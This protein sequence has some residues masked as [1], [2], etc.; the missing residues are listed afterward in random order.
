MYN[1]ALG[2]YEKAL[3]PHH[4]STLDTAHNLESLS[5]SRPSRGCGENVPSC[6]GWTRGGVGTGSHSHSQTSDFLPLKLSSIK[7]GLPIC[8]F[9]Q[10][11]VQAWKFCDID[12][13][14]PNAGYEIT[15]IVLLLGFLH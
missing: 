2:G 5:E 11:K 14:S 8:R 3:G 10:S 1:L 12:R 7:E 6:I 9:S 13:C 15:S 4:R